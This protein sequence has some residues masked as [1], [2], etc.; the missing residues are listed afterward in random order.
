M[1]KQNKERTDGNAFIND[2]FGDS[3]QLKGE[4]KEN[5][6]ETADKEGGDEV[7]GQIPLDDRSHLDKISNIMIGCLTR[8][9]KEKGK[10]NTKLDFLL[11]ESCQFIK[12][13]EESNQWKFQL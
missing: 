10:S 12:M 5:E 7:M 1:P 4:E 6:K 11:V 9:R 8:N 2:H 13:G 3:Q